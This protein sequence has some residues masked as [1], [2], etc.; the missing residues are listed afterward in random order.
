MIAGGGD[1]YLSRADF[2]RVKTGL[3]VLNNLGRLLQSQGYIKVV[4][5]Y[6]GQS[7]AFDLDGFRNVGSNYDNIAARHLR[8]FGFPQSVISEQ[9]L[10]VK[11]I[12]SAKVIINRTTRFLNP[13]FPWRQVVKKYKDIAAF[14]GTEDEWRNFSTTY[15]LIRHI[16]TEN[17]FEV[18]QC[19]SGAQ[20]FI[21]NQ[22]APCAIAEGLK[23]PLIQETCLSIPNCMFN[24]KNAIYVA[25]ETVDLPDL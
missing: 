22:S 15:G 2:T 25:G 1:F 3:P 13:L 16:K 18:A 17:L 11:P 24:R 4:D 12:E 8:A 20:L 14:V 5:L 10:F 9:W 7:V 6:R 21:G 19:I 23:K